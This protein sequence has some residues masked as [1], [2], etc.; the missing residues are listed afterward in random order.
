VG[1][2]ANRN[3]NLKTASCKTVE[4]RYENFHNGLFGARKFFLNNKPSENVCEH[5]KFNLKWK[6]HLSPTKERLHCFTKLV[7]IFHE[8]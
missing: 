5:F 7:Q 3:L 1:K 6:T 8:L 4:F 2:Q